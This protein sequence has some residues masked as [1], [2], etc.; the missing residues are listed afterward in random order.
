MNKLKHFFKGDWYLNLWF[1][2][3][4]KNI[5]LCSHRNIR[6]QNKL[7]YPNDP[8]INTKRQWG[9]HTNGAKRGVKE[10]TCLDWQLNLGHWHINYTNFT[11]NKKY[12]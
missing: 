7:D 8:D 2:K 10:H 12:R 9:I 11:F 4:S 1:D 6:K 3:D 5:Y